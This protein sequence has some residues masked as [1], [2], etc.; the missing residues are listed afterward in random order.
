[1]EYQLIIDD[2]IC[3]WGYNKWNVR[4]DLAPYKGKPVN[5]KISSLG[6]DLNHAF[7]IMQQFI[8]HGNVTAY[9]TGM[10]ASA[11]TVIALGAKHIKISQGAAL[12]VHKC[13]NFIDAWG[14]YNADQIQALIDQLTENKQENDKIDV[15]LAQLYADRAHKSINDIM[16]ILKKGNWLS[17]Q[18]SLDLGFVDEIIPAFPEDKKQN[19]FDDRL[20]AKLNCFGLP[21]DNLSNILIDHA[22]D[23][24]DA[25]SDTPENN[26]HQ[27]INQNSMKTY[28]FNK[29]E[30]LLK[31]DSITPD[32]EGFVSVKADEFEQINSHIDSLES[33]VASK[34]NE[35]KEAQSKA[36]D[37]Q[38]KVDELT[39]QVDA[40]K[41]APADE[42]HDI[43]DEGGEEA[44]L[45]HHDLFNSIKSAL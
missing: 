35:L 10:S 27:P 1:M 25:C 44:K 43:H 2:F 29:V 31:M 11:A 38:K 40:L 18:E 28:K 16:P 14:S 12:L 32:T 26:S 36:D 8:D 13:S 42:S 15:I 39:A 37:L 3:D 21:T 33:S 23:K 17:P 7:D 22:D 41:K 5:V 24:T 19:K 6:G 20:I 30:S 4:R 9:I 34:D 45:N